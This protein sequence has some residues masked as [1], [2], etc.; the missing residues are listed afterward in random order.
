[1]KIDDMSSSTVIENIKELEILAGAVLKLK[2]NS[3]PRRPIFIEFCGTPKSGKSSCINSLNIFLKRNGFKTKVLAERAGICPV[4]DKFDPFFNIWTTCS[5][6]AEL[7][8]YFSN[9]AKNVDVII[10]DRAIFDGLVWFRWMKM[11]GFMD[12]DNFT[13]IAQFLL[14]QKWRSLVDLIFIFKAS[15]SVSMDRE[16]ANLLTR[17]T[18]SIMNNKTLETYNDA[19]DATVEYHKDQ[20]LKVDI[21]DT[22]GKN[23][24]T[25]SYEATKTILGI[26]KDITTERIGYIEQSKLKNFNEKTFFNFGDLDSENLKLKFNYRDE[27]EDNE[28]LVQPIP[29]LTI[30]DKKRDKVLVLKKKDKSLSKDSPEKDKLLVY[31]GGHIRK[32]DAIGKSDNFLSIARNALSREIKEELDIS[33]VPELKNPLCIWFKE[34]EKSKKHLAVLFIYEADFDFINIKLDTYEFVQKKGKSKSGQVFDFHELE[35]EY[36][37]LEDWS[38]IILQEVFDLN[39]GSQAKLFD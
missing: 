36:E 13:S 23:Q 15:P 22:T 34:N 9:E 1:M 30:T 29:I 18:G 39:F 35:K 33:I 27:V 16:Y 3:R 38:K 31:S 8:E 26:L 24:N 7:S 4:K 2:N 17:K 6:I 25:V 11:N 19:I 21:I 32:E 37:N 5:A 20:F 28:M 12:E 10:A 14:M